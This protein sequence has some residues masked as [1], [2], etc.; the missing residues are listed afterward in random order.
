MMVQLRSRPSALVTRRDP[1]PG[2]GW[3]GSSA[4]DPCL[5]TVA[6]ARVVSLTPPRV[7]ILGVRIDG[8]DILPA[9]SDQ[10]SNCYP[11]A[12]CAGSPL[13]GRGKA[14]KSARAAAPGPATVHRRSY[15]SR[16]TSALV[17]PP[18]TE[19]TALHPAPEGCPPGAERGFLSRS[20][21]MTQ[22]R[23]RAMPGRLRMRMRMRM[24]MRHD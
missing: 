12:T 7:A 6:G 14:A 3:K 21:L 8:F 1:H 16:S 18:R 17:M 22:K 23:M 5:R 24:R 11:Q 10:D 20:E 15:N 4:G 13:T 19:P 9:T 2:L